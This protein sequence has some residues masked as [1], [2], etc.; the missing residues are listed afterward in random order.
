VSNTDVDNKDLMLR[1]SRN[2]DVLMVIQLE[3]RE[4]EET[5]GGSGFRA[6]WSR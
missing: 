6:E 4:S 1:W 5:Q 2:T 3:E